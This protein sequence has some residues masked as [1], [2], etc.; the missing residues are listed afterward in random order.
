MDIKINKSKFTDNDILNDA[1][2][3]QKQIA[4]EYN[5][6]ILDSTNSQARNSI[7]A[8]LCEEY[9]ILG[10]LQTEIQKRNWSFSLPI[11]EDISNKVIDNL[12]KKDK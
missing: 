1:V 3:F 2:Y 11:D 10:E 6:L 9:R 4:T 5:Q 8:I 7:I 12:L